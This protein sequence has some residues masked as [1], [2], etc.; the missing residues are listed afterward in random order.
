MAR[1]SVLV[2]HADRRYAELGARPEAGRERA[3]RRHAGARRRGP[4]R[5]RRSVRLEI[6]SAALTPKA[7]PKWL[8][9]MGA[10][11]DWA[12]VPELPPHVQVHAPGVFGPWMAEYVVAWCLVGDAAHEGLPGRPAPA[13]LGRPRAPRPAGRQDADDRRPRGYR[14][15]HR[16]RGARARNMRARRLP[17]RPAGARGLADVS[18]GRDGPRPPREADFVVLLLPL[19]AETRGIIGAEALSTMKSTAW[20]INIARGAVVN[21]SALMEATR[22]AAHRGRGARR[23]RPRAAAAEPPPV[24]DGQRGRDAAHLGPEHARRDRAR[25]QRQPRPLPR[26]PSAAPRR[27]PPPGGTDASA[28]RSTV[29]DPIQLVIFDCDGVLVDSEISVGRRRGARALG[30]TMTEAEVV[31]RF[32]GRS[33]A[34]MAAQIEAHLRWAAAGELGRAVLASVPGRRS[35]RAQTGSRSSRRSTQSPALPASRRAAPTSG[36][37]LHARPH[38]VS[39][40]LRRSD[41]QRQ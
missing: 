35:C 3:D 32:M 17:A 18:G 13:P 16:A 2:Y 38:R 14:P 15:R 19:T 5:T 6:S 37:A 10:G 4:S 9:V 12:L 20:L 25:L 30:W 29:S 26:R 27:R 1:P 22:A 31:E 11:V 33:D 7:G 23:L 28:T 8:Q 21:E 36:D 40:A 34:D 39:P 41:L 24:E